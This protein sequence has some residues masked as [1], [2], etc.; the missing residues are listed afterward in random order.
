MHFFVVVKNMSK[1]IGKNISENLSADHIHTLIDHAKQSATDE[2]K[3][4]ST[5][6]IQKPAKVTDDLIDN[7]IA[8]KITK[9]LK[10]SPQNTSETVENET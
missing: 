7:E 6:A 3:T 10:T 9:V 5:R 1:N 4:G 2:L 8:D